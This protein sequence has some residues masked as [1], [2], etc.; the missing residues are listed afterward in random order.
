MK[1]T[2]EK[3]PASQIGLAIEVSPDQ[4]Q[5]AYE[6]VIRQFSRTANVP[7]FRK[8]KVPRHVLLQRLGAKQIKAAALEELLQ[9]AVPK[10]IAQESISAISNPEFSPPLEELISRYEPG[11][12][13]V[14]NLKV[15]VAP[16]V[17]LG[18]YRG[19]EVE[20]EEVIF[21]PTRVDQ[22][23]EKERENLAT[24][25]P[26]E[27]RPAELGDTALVD[28]EV[29][30]LDETGEIAEPLPGGKAEGFQM[31]LAMGKFVAGLAEGIAGMEPGTS[32]E[33]TI[34]F[35]EDYP[36]ADLTGRTTRFVV[37]LKELKR[38]ELPPLDDELAQSAAD[39]ATLEQ[40]RSQLSEREQQQAEQKTKQNQH[41][42]LVEALLQRAEVE[43]PESLIRE[44]IS[45]LISRAALELYQQGI[46]IQKFLDATTV[47]QMRTESRP[48]AIKHL[49]SKLVLLEI[50]KQEG[51]TVDDT[52]V[53]AQMRQL[54]A[55]AQEN[56]V[57]PEEL[58]QEITEN[59][60]QAK[61]LEWL[62]EQ[63]KVTLVSPPPPPTTPPAT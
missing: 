59:L 56:K 62:G 11:E 30:L 12:A 40:W 14:I 39:I 15:D 22:V 16:T 19:L 53:E 58:R 57:N 27:D 1:V 44:E 51:L 32:R 50:A 33:L 2:Q 17:T 21:D 49:K 54:A 38:K 31:E 3:L 10:A 46:D 43:L 23:L 26:V 35:P 45:S 52:T 18:D 55:Q 63:A 6:Q 20:V 37:T 9:E 13:L 36:N 61:V 7:G 28:Y 34:Q 42:A 25:V 60:L 48:Q 4:S 24:L 5:A 41:S 29:F 47:Q 8:G